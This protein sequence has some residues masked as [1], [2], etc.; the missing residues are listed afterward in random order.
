MPV[1]EFTLDGLSAS[2]TEI[3]IDAGDTVLMHSSLLHLGLLADCAPGEMPGRVVSGLMDHLGPSGTLAVLAPFYGYSNDNTP[4]DTRH[5][6]VSHELGVLSTAVAEH[7]NAL[8]S[9]NPIFSLAA[10]GPEA[11]RICLQSNGSAFG[12]GSAW[13]RAVD[14]GA[15]ILLLGSTVQRMTLVRYIE[16]RAGVPYLYVKLFQTPVFR[17]GVEL[18]CAVT[19]LLRYAHLPLEYDLSDFEAQLLESG[20]M[21][22]ASIGGG[23]AYAVNAASCVR[24][25]LEALAD[26]MHFFLASPPAYDAAELPLR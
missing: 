26:D 13:E 20:I 8:R 10:I 4:F 25:G 7:A 22:A 21:N 24:L 1:A 3:G 6:P 2:L 18:D 23:H 17:D 5:S 16:Q 12:A 19:A 15:K 14:A 9:A 11:E